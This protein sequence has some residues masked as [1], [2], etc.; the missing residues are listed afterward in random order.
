MKTSLWIV[1]VFSAMLMV[2]AGCN[3]SQPP[4]AEPAAV[5]APEIETGGAV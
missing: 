3:S 4:E 1:A 2:L 5:V